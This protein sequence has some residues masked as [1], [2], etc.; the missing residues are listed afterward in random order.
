MYDYVR[1]I[2]EPE[3]SFNDEAGMI[4]CQFFF[5]L[6]IEQLQSQITKCLGASKENRTVLQWQLPWYSFNSFDNLLILLWRKYK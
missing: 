5:I 6:Q 3:I 4:K 2:W 1:E